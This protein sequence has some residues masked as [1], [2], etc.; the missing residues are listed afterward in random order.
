MPETDS[1]TLSDLCKVV[2]IP[3]SLFEKTAPLKEEL[4]LLSHVRSIDTF[5]KPDDMFNP[6]TAV[7]YS[8]ILSNRF[9]PSAETIAPDNLK[10]SFYLVSLEG[11]ADYLPVGE[12]SIS[13]LK[14]TEFTTVRLVCFFTWDVYSEKGNSADFNKLASELSVAPFTF[15]ETSELISP[16]ISEGYTPMCHYTRSGEK[17]VSLYRSPLIPSKPENIE[18]IPKYDADG[19]IGY[20]EENGIFDMTYAAAWQLGRILTLSHKSIATEI[21]KKRRERIY[22]SAQKKNNDCVVAKT[23]V[24]AGE[25]TDLKGFCAN[26]LLLNIT[27][28]SIL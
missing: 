4:H 2:D 9:I 5:D 26:T 21:I 23:A 1:E 20:N 7:T 10:S 19:R 28:N 24:F 13:S 16:F 12:N 6:E 25:S 14:N 27:E 22:K 11:V 8:E 15:E 18:A 3:L 17:T